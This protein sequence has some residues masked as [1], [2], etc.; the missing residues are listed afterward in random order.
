M[1]LYKYNNSKV[2]WMDFI[3]DGVRVRESTKSR[4][5]KLAQDIERKR[6]TE[7]ESGRMGLRQRERPRIFSLVAE[8]YLLIKR[9]VL[10][11]RGLIIEK[12]NLKHLLAAFGSKLLSDI[13][14]AE[15][16]IYQRNRR[17]LGAAPKT[18][19]LEIG[20][21]RAILLRHQ[22]WQFIKQDVRM[23]KVEESVGTALSSAQEQALLQACAESRSRTLHP[24]VVL[25]LNT[26][27][28]SIEIRSLRW[29]QV[30]LAAKLVRVGRSK[31]E[32]GAGRMIPLNGRATLTLQAWAALFPSRTPDHFVFPSE[33][34]GQNGAAYDVHPEKPMGSFK[35]GWE[36]AR[37][38]SGI[39]CRFHDL[40][41]TACTRLLE[42][43]V[44]FALL[45][46][47]MGWSPSS[48]VKMAK[49]YGHIGDSTLRQAMALLEQQV[50]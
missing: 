24:A 5:K 40:R 12:S 4:S 42:G 22:L 15:I 26:G 44:T 32:A 35:E 9:P 23:L 27:M 30:D 18:I 13:G 39:Q 11:E 7:L 36:A 33:R 8:D 50:A 14:A 2:W 28:R 10:S 16:D 25:A 41:H 49:R 46:Q 34:Y 29:L 37:K 45:A 19:N 20:T 38:R 1:S 43:G 21:L 6:R 3:F 48:T 17:S 47:I 31:T